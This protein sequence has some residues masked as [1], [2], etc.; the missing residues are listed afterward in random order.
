MAGKKSSGSAIM[1]DSE[2]FSTITDLKICSVVFFVKVNI[3]IRLTFHIRW[4]PS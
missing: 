2:R 1:V 3:F 4:V